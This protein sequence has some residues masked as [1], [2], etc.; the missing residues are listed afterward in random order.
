MAAIQVAD[1]EMTG[2]D[3]KPVK[4]KVIEAQSVDGIT[5]QI[6]VPLEFAPELAAALEGRKVVTATKLPDAPEPKPSDE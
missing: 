2:P 3:G 6:I 5:A 4:V 1:A